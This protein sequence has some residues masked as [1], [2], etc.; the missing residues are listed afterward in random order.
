M[1]EQTALVFLVSEVDL[2]SQ[3]SR[4]G[5][6]AI[7]W[8]NVLFVKRAKQSNGYAFSIYFS[9][10]ES[11]QMFHASAPEAIALLNWWENHVP[12]LQDGTEAIPMA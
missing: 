3:F 8:D 5:E 2:N 11:P 7:N 9:G 10:R 12:E 6:L 1:K 4:M